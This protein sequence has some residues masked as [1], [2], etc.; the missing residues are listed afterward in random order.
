MIKIILTILILNVTLALG[1]EK[2]KDDLKNKVRTPLGLIDYNFSADTLNLILTSDFLY[3]PFGVYKNH[4]GLKKDYPKLYSLRNGFSYLT[5]GDSYAKF[6]FDDDKTK[7]ETVYALVTSS[8]FRLTNGIRTG[9]SKK[10]VMTKFFISMPDNLDNISVLRLE[11]GLVGIWHYYKFD[12][13]I[14]ISICF[15]TDYQLEKS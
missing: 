5:Y 11:S 13:D 9:M 12:N 7:L 8:Q 1:Q 4:E 3:Y 15:D 14:L 10:E 6:F 2:H